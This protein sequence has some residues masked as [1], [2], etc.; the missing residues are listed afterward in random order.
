M[1]GD[2]NL[3]PVEKE[4]AWRARRRWWKGWKYIRWQSGAWKRFRRAWWLRHIPLAIYLSLRHFHRVTVELRICKEPSRG[5]CVVQN[6]EVELVVVVSHS[7][8]TPDDLLELGH[9]V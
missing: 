3:P 4:L 7:C 9:R 8:S 2:L 5:A 6:V 1:R